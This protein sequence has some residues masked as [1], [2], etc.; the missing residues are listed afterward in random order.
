[1][2]ND[3]SKWEGLFSKLSSN[4]SELGKDLEQVVRDAGETPAGKKVREA[5][6]EATPQVKRAIERVGPEVMR[7]VDQVRPEVQKVVDQVRPQVKSAMDQIFG[8]PGAG[9]E[10]A[11]PRRSSPDAPPNVSPDAWHRDPPTASPG[12]RDVPPP[13]APTGAGVSGSKPAAATRST[14]SR[15]KTVGRGDRP[16]PKAKSGVGKAKKPLGRKPPKE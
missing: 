10:S 12:D 4:L 9:S 11:P 8:S 3:G 6:R 2:A 16:Q 13:P 5:V 14:K 15:G 7:V 1:M